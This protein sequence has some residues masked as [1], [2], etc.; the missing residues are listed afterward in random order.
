MPRTSSVSG[1][2]LVPRVSMMSSATV[3]QKVLNGAIPPT[4]REEVEQFSL[5][6]LINQA[7]SDELELVRAQNRALKAEGRLDELDEQASKSG[8]E[9]A[10]SAVVARLET[11][12]AELPRKLVQAKE[13]AIEEF[14]SLEDFKFSNLGI[15]VV[16]MEMDAGF[17]EKDAGFTEE[18]EEMSKEGEKEAGYEDEGEGQSTTTKSCQRVIWWDS[19]PKV[20]SSFIHPSGCIVFP[21]NPTREV[22]KGCTLSS[23][24]FIL[25]K[26][27]MN[28]M[29][30][31]LP[32]STKILWTL[33]LAM[34][35]ATTKAS[36]WGKCKPL[37]SPLLKL[38]HLPDPNP[39]WITY[40][41][42]AVGLLSPYLLFVNFLG[43]FDEFLM[44]DLY[45]HLGDGGIERGQDQSGSVRW[46]T[47]ASFDALGV[48][49]DDLDSNE[50]RLLSCRGGAGLAIGIALSVLDRCCD[51]GNGLLSDES[52]EISQHREWE[53]QLEVVDWPRQGAVSSGCYFHS[54][55]SFFR[56]YRVSHGVGP[57]DLELGWMRE[58][59]KLRRRRGT[60]GGGQE[61]EGE[62][63]DEA[64][65][66]PSE[67]PPL[68][69][70]VHQQ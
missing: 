10:K 26:V 4:D 3:A 48:S 32:L 25:L 54:S 58:K 33:K 28:K 17:T 12:V 15:D 41:S 35:A 57:P 50:D 24:I 47:G 27:E 13:L 62:E 9:S 38:V 11:E 20:T 6:D 45:E 8:A 52:D 55:T 67:F 51:S 63:T 1:N 46:S 16:N 59:M 69:V 14:K 70:K 43:P 42:P 34:T 60:R 65:F 29:S 39:P 56:P 68:K 66:E 22:W 37:R 40:V 19:A 23:P 44:F 36:S 30:A 61:G 2:N 49:L 18:E 21:P 5:E 53:E 7:D 31:E 64:V